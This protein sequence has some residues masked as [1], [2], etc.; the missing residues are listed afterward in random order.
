MSS[1]F[2]VTFNVFFMT[3][4]KQFDHVWVVTVF[5]VCLRFVELLGSM[6]LNFSSSLVNFLSLF[7]HVWLFE[8]VLQ[9]TDVL[10]ISLSL[11]LFVSY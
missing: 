6:D 4:F 11:F 1:F 9:F 2:L 8:V 3:G 5:S 10:F 7:L